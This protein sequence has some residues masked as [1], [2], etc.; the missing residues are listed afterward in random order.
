MEGGVWSEEVGS[1]MS[2]Y[3]DEQMER[4]SM[5]GG[6]YVANNVQ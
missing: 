5:K 6:G 4:R 1:E 2:R 3:A